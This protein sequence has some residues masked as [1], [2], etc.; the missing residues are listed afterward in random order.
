MNLLL[1]C[2]GGASFVLPRLLVSRVHYHVS[3]K[4]PREESECDVSEAI[5]ASSKGNPRCPLA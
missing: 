5:H 3:L 4:A 1:H 2:R